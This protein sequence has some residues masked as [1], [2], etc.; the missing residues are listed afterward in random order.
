METPKSFQEAGVQ[1]PLGFW[2]PLGL[3]TSGNVSDYKRRREV[4]LKHGNLVHEI[5]GRIKPKNQF[6]LGRFSIHHCTTIES[7]TSSPIECP[8]QHPFYSGICCAKGTIMGDGFPIIYWGSIGF[9][10]PKKVQDLV[11]HP[12]IQHGHHKEYF[13]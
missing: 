13:L 5:R 3:S 12:E 8:N 1:A 4:E 10:H 6:R 2:D 7:G 11:R 9:I